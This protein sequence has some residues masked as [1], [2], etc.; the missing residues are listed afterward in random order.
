M[1][2]NI[3]IF[4]IISLIAGVT[5]YIALDSLLIAIITLTIFLIMSIFVFSPMIS[6]YVIKVKKFHECYHFINNFVIALS[7]KKSIS[8]SFETTVNSMPNEFIELCEGLENMTEKEKLNYF[9][10]Y[11][12]FYVY[13]L[14]IQIVDLWE[15]QGGDILQMSKYL[16]TEIRYNEEYITKTDSLSKHKYVEIGILWAFS[17][18]VIIILRFALKDFYQSVKNQLLYMLAIVIV[19]A[20]IL[21]TIFLLINKGTSLKLKGNNHEKNS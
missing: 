3:L 10:S 21:L 16:I 9:S 5:S 17:L 19:M 15:D 7:I 8:G 14:F 20:F 12:N 1:K 11:F 18:L 4:V 2:N 6:R 13:Q